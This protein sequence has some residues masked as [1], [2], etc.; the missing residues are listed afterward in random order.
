MAR[1]SGETWISKTEPHTLKYY[2]GGTEYWANSATTYKAGENITKGN[3]LAIS[4]SDAGSEGKVFRASFP[5]N[6]KDIIGIALNDASINSEVRVINYGYLLLTRGEL[7]ALFVTQSDI[8]VGAID[9]TGFYGA[10]T[11]FGTMSDSGGGNG[12]SSSL[13]S[14]NGAPI[15][16]YQGRLIKTDASS[17]EMQQPTSKKGLLTLSTP[18]GYKYPEPSLL[19]WGD[20]SFDVGY[21]QLPVIGNVY[22]Y[23]HD[24]TD[25]TEMVIHVNFTRFER[26]IGFTYPAE[27]LHT[28][29]EVNDPEIIPLRHGLFTD[30]SIFPHTELTMLGSDDADINGEIFKVYPGYD[31]T[32]GTSTTTVTIASDSPFHGKVMGEVSYTL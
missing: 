2:A 1:K 16:W 14:G 18:S 6:L 23:V 15:Y 32:R 12:W 5:D 27:G 9:S 26:K 13:W 11:N 21:S 8:T 25:I 24:G 7:E 28:Y 30:S 22:Q 29:D 20:Q 17:Y 19:A 4:K 10:G 3:I 31:S